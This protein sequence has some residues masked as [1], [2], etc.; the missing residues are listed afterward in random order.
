MDNL[1]K[2]VVQQTR[3]L[4]SA[5]RATLFLID[6][7]S[8]ELFSKVADLTEEIRIPTGTGIV[9]YVAKSGEALNIPDAYKDPRFDAS[10]D[11]RTRY[12][13]RSILCTP[14]RARDGTVIGAA[15]AINKTEGV[16]TPDDEKMME[17]FCDQI[18]IAANN[19]MEMN[20][21]K[22]RRQSLR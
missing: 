9:G 11:R 15:Q 22:V 17:A 1:F 13:T 21:S 18:G 8:N 7:Q 14:I 20:R 4:L 6:T 2:N 10:T 3:M 12:K 5:D 19:C 16:F